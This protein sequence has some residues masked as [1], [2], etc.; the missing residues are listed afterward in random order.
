MKR[1]LGR[2]VPLRINGE[3]SFAFDCTREEWSEDWMRQ[4][5]ETV[6]CTWHFETVNQVKSKSLSNK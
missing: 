2:F 1:N 4:K 6:R 5:P 3:E